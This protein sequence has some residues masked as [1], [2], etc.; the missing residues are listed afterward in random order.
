MAAGIVGLM[1][2]AVYLGIVIGEDEAGGRV[3]VFA[4][5]L[6]VVSMVTFVS[7]LASALSPTAR[8]VL[9]GA[10]TGG[11]FT[12]GGA[13]DFSIR[14]PLLGAGGACA[15]L[16]GRLAPAAHGR[17]PGAPHL[18]APPAVGVGGALP[19]PDAVWL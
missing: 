8:L 2:D 18:P 14:L 10:A 19:L 15:V 1:V 7:A 5:F 3:A 12:A 13:G 4:V 17:S 16:W 6:L 9:L 11:F